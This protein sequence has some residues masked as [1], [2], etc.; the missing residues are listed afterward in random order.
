MAGKAAPPE[1]VPADQQNAKEPT[2]QRRAAPAST[3][4][5]GDER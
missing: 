4:R 3:P 1:Q 2:E 5:F